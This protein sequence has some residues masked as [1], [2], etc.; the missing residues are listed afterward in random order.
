MKNFLNI[1]NYGN[2]QNNTMGHTCPECLSYC[3]CSGDWDDTDLGEWSG[4][5]HYLSDGCQHDQEDP[6]DYGDEDDVL[7]PLPN[8]KDDP[9]QLNLFNETET[10]CPKEKSQIPVKMHIVR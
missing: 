2:F 7:T 1:C 9:N 5:Q 8:I 3:T 4:C 10:P 6:D